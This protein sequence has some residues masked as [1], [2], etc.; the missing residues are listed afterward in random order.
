M[1]LCRTILVEQFLRQSD[2]PARGGCGFDLPRNRKQTS[3]VSMSGRSRSVLRR[4]PWSPRD[5]LD[6]GSSGGVF[7]GPV[8]QLDVRRLHEV[9]IALKLDQNIG[10]QLFARHSH[11]VV[12]TV[13]A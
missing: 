11:H 2:I 10:N 13:A 9:E 12:S 6:T 4:L 7:G 5:R 3:S 1:Q 8:H